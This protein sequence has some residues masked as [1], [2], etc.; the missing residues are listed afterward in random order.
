MG[1]IAN[2][3]VMLIQACSVIFLDHQ[4][5]DYSDVSCGTVSMVFYNSARSHYSSESPNVSFNLITVI[6]SVLRL[7]NVMGDP[8]FKKGVTEQNVFI[9]IELLLPV[10]AVIVGSSSHSF[11]SALGSLLRLLD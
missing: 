5:P 2:Y 10:P 8:F 11:I 4:F 1:S 3:G 6:S 9:P 7:E